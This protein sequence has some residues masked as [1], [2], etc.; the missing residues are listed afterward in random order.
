MGQK[1]KEQKMQIILRVGEEGEEEG[2]RILATVDFVAGLLRT[3]V[4]RSQPCPQQPVIIV[5]WA[6]S[7]WFPRLSCSSSCSAPPALLLLLL[8]LLLPPSFTSIS[9]VFIVSSGHGPASSTFR[10]QSEPVRLFAKHLSFDYNLTV[11]VTSHRVQGQAERD[12]R[13]EE[14]RG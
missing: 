4:L 11:N 9:T 5:L 1:P 2:R 7:F 8:L 10:P 3:I 12:G 6:V 13:L 14:I